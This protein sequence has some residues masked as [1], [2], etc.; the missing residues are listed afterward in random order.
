MVKRLIAAIAVT[1]V[2]LGLIGSTP[3]RAQA[4]SSPIADLEKRVHDLE[5]KH[6]RHAEGAAA[7][8]APV[9]WM[10]GCGLFCARWARTTG[11]DPWLWLGAGLM[12][13]V[14]TLFAVLSK[15]EEDKKA[16]AKPPVHELA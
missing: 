8:V 2:M 1:T 16:R 5:T 14:F 11:R 15:H 6:T 9:L 12:F 10:I 4:P 3:A 7:V 13:N